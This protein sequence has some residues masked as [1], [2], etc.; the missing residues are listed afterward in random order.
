M[1]PAQWLCPAQLLRPGASHLENPGPRDHPPALAFDELGVE[2]NCLAWNFLLS[3][4][5]RQLWGPKP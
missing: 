5:A 2:A 1:Q 4:L 3:G